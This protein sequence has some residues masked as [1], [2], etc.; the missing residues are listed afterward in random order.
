MVPVK[1]PLFKGDR[2]FLL[3]PP[4]F[5]RRPPW[6]RSLLFSRTTSVGNLVENSTNLQKPQQKMVEAAGIE[7]SLS[8]SLFC[9]KVR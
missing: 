7:T 5:S 2:L 6:F 4:F 3:F 1:L 8:V 9:D